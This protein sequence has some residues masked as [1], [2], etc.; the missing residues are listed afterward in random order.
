MVYRSGCS[1]QEVRSA[2]TNCIFDQWGPSR[3]FELDTEPP[4]P[5]TP[6]FLPL[7]QKTRIP[8]NIGRST[9]EHLFNLSK[10][11]FTHI[12][13][14]FAIC[15]VCKLQYYF[16]NSMKTKQRG[17]HPGYFH[18]ILPFGMPRKTLTERYKDRKFNVWTEF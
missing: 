1:P 8:K 5:R 6:S 17:S 4:N 15:K 16:T 13:C 10:R 7:T 3:Y 14:S 11:G 9:L 18:P 12:I 2:G